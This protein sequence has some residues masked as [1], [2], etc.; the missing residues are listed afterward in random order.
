MLSVCVVSLWIV[1]MVDERN[2]GTL[3]LDDAL[4]L[5]GNRSSLRAP[6]VNSGSF[7]GVSMANEPLSR[8]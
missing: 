5:K 1:T 7:T 8:A 6:E 3:L 2:V 4:R